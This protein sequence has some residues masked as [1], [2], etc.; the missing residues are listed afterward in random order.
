MTN[1]TVANTTPIISLCSIG[2]LDILEKLFGEIIVPEA[3]YSEIKNKEHYGYEEIDSKFIKVEK[4]KGISY[5]D[6]LLNQLDVGEAETII[7]AKELNADNV[8]IDEK[9]G[10]QIARNTGLNVV[11]TLSILL[12][13]KDKGIIENVR[14]SLDEML[15]KGRWYSKYVYNEFLKKAKEL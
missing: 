6:L 4:I 2:K 11:R 13:A 9:L 3:V 14:P 1:P 12:L 15:Q 5:R 10:Y 7:L 8:I